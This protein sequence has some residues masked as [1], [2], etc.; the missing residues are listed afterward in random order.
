MMMAL[1]VILRVGIEN[2]PY[3]I[4]WDETQRN[5]LYFQRRVLPVHQ[6]RGVSPRLRGAF[7]PPF[8]TRSWVAIHFARTRVLWPPHSSRVLGAIHRARGGA[9]PSRQFGARSF[10][11]LVRNGWGVSVFR[12]SRL[13]NRS[14]RTP[15]A[16]MIGVGL[17]GEVVV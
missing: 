2:V 3:R 17:A 8:L 14:S 4:K 15:T 7:C 10:I 5:V 12:R 13:T 11:A 6:T 9:K 16:A 1:L